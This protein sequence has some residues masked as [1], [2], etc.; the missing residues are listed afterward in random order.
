MAHF[1][2]CTKG[3]IALPACCQQVPLNFPSLPAPSWPFPSFFL[4]L[5]LSHCFASEWNRTMTPLLWKEVSGE[6]WVTS[7]RNKLSHF[8]LNP[9]ESNNH[10][11]ENQ[12]QHEHIRER[13]PTP[14]CI[15]TSKL[16][17]LLRIDRPRPIDLP[18]PAS[19]SLDRSSGHGLDGRTDGRM[20]W[21]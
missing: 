3:V 8:R 19:A 2:L 4:C 1:N 11:S 21:D 12:L 10:H 15:R 6:R 16:Q 13:T 7:T 17:T 14:S 18:S 9:T 20:A 5:H